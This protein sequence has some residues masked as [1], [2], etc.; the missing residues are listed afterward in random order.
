[1]LWHPSV[2]KPYLTLLAESSNPATLEGAAGS[3]QNLSAGTWRVRY[4]RHVTEE[5]RA[6]ISVSYSN[7][8]QIQVYMTN[9]ISFCLIFIWELLWLQI[10]HTALIMHSKVNRYQ[11]NLIYF[12]NLFNLMK[13][14][15]S[16]KGVGGEDTVVFELLFHAVL[17][18]T[19]CGEN[20]SLQKSVDNRFLF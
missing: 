12:R 5:K 15:E 13:A 9:Q 8:I 19:D 4:C 3:L 10:T 2:V 17:K 16:C 6:W 20:P 7:L 14:N 11:I 1:M 18:E